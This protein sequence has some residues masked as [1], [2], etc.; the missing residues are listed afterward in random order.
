MQPR[1]RCRSMP[2]GSTA[3]LPQNSLISLTSQLAVH[4]VVPAGGS[5][6]LR[7]WLAPVLQQ[8]LHVL[9]EQQAKAYDDIREKLERTYA[10]ND[11]ATEAERDRCRMRTSTNTRTRSNESATQS[12]P[13]T[14]KS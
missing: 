2:E 6:P 13:P 4:L 11:A 7:T 5:S 3:Q 12:M 10:L 8:R 14:S 9:K 1:H